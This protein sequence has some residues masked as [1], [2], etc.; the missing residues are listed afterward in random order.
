MIFKNIMLFNILSL[1]VLAFLFSPMAHSAD[2]WIVCANKFPHANSYPRILGQAIVEIKDSQLTVRFKADE[3]AETEIKIVTDTKEVDSDG[4]MAS[5]MYIPETMKQ[6][7]GKGK[8]TMKNE[9]GE[10]REY[11]FMLYKENSITEGVEIV[12]RKLSILG[13]NESQK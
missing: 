3:N 2:V 9:N 11:D 4:N 5:S 10:P 13:N 7:Q 12:V 6:M 8:I 1:A